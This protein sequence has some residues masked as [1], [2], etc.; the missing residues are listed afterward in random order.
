LHRILSSYW[1]AHFY[2]LKIS[3]KGLHYFGLDCGMLEYS[4]YSRAVIQRI[5]DDFPAFLE[6]GSA[7]KIAVCARTNRDPSKQEVD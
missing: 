3:A 6:Q 5:I 7:E 2:L 4:I 1:L